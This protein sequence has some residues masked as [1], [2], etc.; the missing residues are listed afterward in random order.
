[1]LKGLRRAFVDGVIDN[2]ENEASAKKHTQFKTRVKKPYPI[3]WSTWSVLYSASWKR[4]APTVT[5]TLIQACSQESV[6]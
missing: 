1:M 5:Y 4:G 3:S 6:F 2:D